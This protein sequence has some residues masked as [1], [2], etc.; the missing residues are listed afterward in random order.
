M[1]CE[2][3]SFLQCM[4]RT[5]PGVATRFTTI[6]KP[7]NMLWTQCQS[8]DINRLMHD[9]IRV[10]ANCGEYD[11]LSRTKRYSSDPLFRQY[12]HWN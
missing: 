4:V 10:D 3:H 2:R 8:C 5:T 1:P 11:S 9:F 6:S 7:C 12:L